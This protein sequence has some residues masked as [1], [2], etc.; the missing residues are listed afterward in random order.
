MT[1]PSQKTS[2]YSSKDALRTF[3]LTTCGGFALSMVHSCNDSESGSVN[4]ALAAI[5]GLAAG[6]VFTVGD[7]L[8]NKKDK[9]AGSSRPWIPGGGPL[10]GL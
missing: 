6:I 9:F 8:R 3:A 1:D 10:P 7:Y 4:F 5:F 2:T